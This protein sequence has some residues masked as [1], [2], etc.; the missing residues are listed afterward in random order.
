MRYSHKYVLC[1][2]IVWLLALGHLQAWQRGKAPAINPADSALGLTAMNIFAFPNINKV[3]FY[4]NP[5]QKEKIRA[6]SKQQNWQELYPVLRAYVGKFGIENFY[7]ETYYLWRLA[8]LTELYGSLEEAKL[9]YKLVLKHHRADIDLRAVELGY[10]SLDR[11]TG[12]LFVPLEY[13]YELVE[14]RQEVDTLR[15]P[16]GVVLD[17]GPA[18]NAKAADYG[19]TLSANDR[20]LIFTSKRNYKGNAIDRRVNEDIF[21]SQLDQDDFWSTARSLD[22]INS[23]Y[24]EG[25][26]CL[27]KDGKTLYF[28]RCQSPDS[29]GNC[30]IFMAQLQQDSTWGNVRNLGPQVNS[31]GWD[32][33]PTLTHSEDTLYFASDRNGGFGLSDI[34]FSY[35]TKNGWAPAQNAGPIVN[36]RNNEVSPFYHPVYHVL[37]LSSNGHLLNFGEF[38][39]FKCYRLSN[40]TWSEPKNIGPLVNGAGSEFYF[41]IDS[42]SRNIYYARSVENK[43]DLL[44]LYSFPLPMEAQ[45]LATTKLRG[46]L[47]D[48]LTGEPFQG[49]VSII[50]LD[51]GIEVAPQYL[52]PDGSYEFDLINNNKYLLIIQGSEFFRIEEVFTLKGDTVIEKRAEPLASRI[53]FESIAFELGESALRP[54]MLDDLDKIVSFLLDNP[55]FRLRIAGHTDSN[56]DPEFNLELSEQRAQAIR[57]YIV[58][59]NPVEPWRV[60]AKGFGSQ[61]PIVEEKTEEDRRLNR[62]VEFEIYRP[63]PEQLKKEETEGYQVANPEWDR[64]QKKKNNRP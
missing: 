39:L 9:L 63:T 18:I 50:D 34:W 23:L 49:I 30:D 27:S 29:Y 3:R 41:T 44:D 42:K 58:I 56:G 2:F 13:Y 11:L 62:R 52:R 6:L 24:N 21:I 60:Q 38:D 17:M 32:S 36:T 5:K 19:P 28:A 12:N 40:N 31:R 54:E 35:K 53:K 59:F 57:D 20:T 48:T 64:A 43:M 14:Y 10:D 8:K 55:D 37:Y 61:E 4:S 1:V 47:T 22:Q 7:K 15:P 45:P 51:N 26:A 16:R 33:H 25:S 46:S